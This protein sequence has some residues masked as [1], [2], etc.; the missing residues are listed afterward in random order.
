MS[1][2][3]GKRTKLSNLVSLHQE[4]ECLEEMEDDSHPLE[5]EVCEEPQLTTGF[6]LTD[7]GNG[8]RLVARH[9]KDLLYH[10]ARKK[11]LVWDGKRWAV[12]QTGEIVRRAKETVMS[13]YQEAEAASKNESKAELLDFARSCENRYRIEAMIN[14][15]QSEAGIP[16]DPNELDKDTWLLNVQ[17]GTLNL[18]TGELLSHDRDD[19]ITLLAPVKHKPEAKCPLWEKFMDRIFDGDKEL[20]SYLQKALGYS[21]TGSTGEQCFFILYG[22]GCN[23]KTTLL[24]T[25]KAVLGEYAKDTNPQTFMEKSGN[26]IPNDL[27]ALKGARFVKA[28]EIDQGRRMSESLMKQITGGDTISA[29][30]LY[31]EYFSYI[32]QCKIFMATNHRPDIQGDDYGIWRRV[33]LIPFEVEIPPEERDDNLGNKLR[34]ELSGILN[35]LLE[36]CLRWQNEGLGMPPKVEAATQEY[37]KEMDAIWEWLEEECETDDPNAVE[38]A[39][40]LYKSYVKWSQENN[41]KEESQTAFGRSLTRRKFKPDRMSGGRRIRHGIKLKCRQ[42]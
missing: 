14:I 15:S 32:P 23:G 13:I 26:S 39:S 31:G 34:T 33:H 28:V 2:N 42:K 12:D 7:I 3:V 35:W 1:Q 10:Y 40:D 38:A 4:A 22:D 29:R 24:E 8:Q 16:V 27:A 19:L 30:F 11:W 9:G 17:N 37:Q 21:L 5:A 6:N 25:V 18:R 36:G 41:L 20:I